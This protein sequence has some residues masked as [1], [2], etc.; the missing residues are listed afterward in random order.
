MPISGAYAGGLGSGTNALSKEEFEYV[1]SGGKRGVRPENFLSL[2]KCVAFKVRTGRL[3]TGP[4]PFSVQDFGKACGGGG[5]TVVSVE[6]MAS[7]RN[8]LTGESDSVA[9]GWLHG[10]FFNVQDLFLTGKPVKKLFAEHSETAEAL[11]RAVF[12]RKGI[13]NPKYV[14]ARENVFL[15]ESL[16]MMPEY[17]RLGFASKTLAMLD[18]LLE[19]SCGFET[20]CIATYSPKTSQSTGVVSLKERRDRCF[21][22]AGFRQVPRHPFLYRNTD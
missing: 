2:E 15:V 13:M 5:R 4:M 3:E 7:V 14:G 10:T 20:G 11:Y 16:E 18:S 22:E 6:I 19:Y 9:A 8:L 12:D 17:R 21:A 1:V